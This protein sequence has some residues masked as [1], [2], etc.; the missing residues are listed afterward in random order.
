MAWL[1]AA[2]YQRNIWRDL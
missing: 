1:R 2:C